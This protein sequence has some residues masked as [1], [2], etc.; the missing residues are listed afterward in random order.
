[1][2]Q[3]GYQ[4]PQVSPATVGSQLCCS[5]TSV[6]SL[7][8]TPAFAKCLQLLHPTPQSQ[9][10]GCTGTCP[11]TPQTP[12]PPKNLP[13]P[14]IKWFCLHSTSTLSP[15][16]PAFSNYDQIKF[17]SK[18]RGPHMLRAGVAFCLRQGPRWPG[19]AWSL[20]CST[21]DF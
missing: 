14:N 5:S 18:Q 10:L 2:G 8:S 1:M 9:P 6:I 17:N 13:V 16:W 12:A 3:N 21:D 7:G 19:P 11:G 15:Q 20:L 4:L